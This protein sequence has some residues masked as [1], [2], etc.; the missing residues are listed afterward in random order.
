MKRV[1][2]IGGATYDIFIEYNNATTTEIDHHRFLLLHEGRK[3]DVESVSYY[4]GGGATNSAASFARLGFDTH[5]FFKIGTDFQ[6]SFI[7]DSLKKEQV[8]VHHVVAPDVPTSSS[9]II[10]MPSGDNTILVYRGANNCLTQQEIPA[11]L[12]SQQDQLYVTSLGGSSAALL[13]Y[14]V[15]IA[16][17]NGIPVAVN[18]GRSQI[19]TGM[20]SLCDALPAIDILILNCYEASECMR[21]LRPKDYFDIPAFCRL[22]RL[23]GPKIVAVT[24]GA[25]GVYVAHEDT[26]LFHPSLPP[27]SI[28]STVGAG[29]AFGSC[30][31]AQIALGKSIDDAMRA[32]ILNSSSV[33]GHVGA[34]TG[35]LTQEEIES[36]IIE[37]DPLLWHEFE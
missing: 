21:A 31:V 33:L 4:S 36:K 23:Q 9:F 18:P 19:T 12:I 22:M 27:A 29:D 26:L 24:D 7:L 17:K 28:V 5:T 32:G 30:F 20:K 34:K 14:I 37:I 2:T 1:L 8:T 35:L 13:P 25:N 16:K 11:D 6:G 10:P 3:I 15:G